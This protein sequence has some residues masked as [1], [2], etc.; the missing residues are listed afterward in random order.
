VLSP[1]LERRAVQQHGRDDCRHG[2]HRFF[3]ASVST[4]MIATTVMATVMVETAKIAE[5]N[6]VLLC[7]NSQIDSEKTSIV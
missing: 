1:A 7:W 4:K 2:A 3:P 5:L 6:E